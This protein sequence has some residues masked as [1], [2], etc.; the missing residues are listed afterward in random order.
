M[1]QV[2]AVRTSSLYP[3]KSN[4]KGGSAAARDATL[5]AP[6]KITIIKRETEKSIVF[7]YTQ[8]K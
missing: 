4:Q 1:T 2:D 3:L 7:R 5:T 8:K 6:V